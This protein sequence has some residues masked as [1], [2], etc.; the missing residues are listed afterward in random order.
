M[1]LRNSHESWIHGGGKWNSSP[2]VVG[3]SLAL[4][5]R[6]TRLPLPIVTRHGAE[7]VAVGVPQV[8]VT[9]HDLSFVD[10]IIV[11]LDRG[12]EMTIKLLSDRGRK[13]NPKIYCLDRQHY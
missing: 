7:L 10:R 11:P 6:R 9:L 8:F 5:P 3:Q 12:P 13:K 4:A 1:Q 2:L